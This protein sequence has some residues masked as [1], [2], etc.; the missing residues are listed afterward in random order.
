MNGSSG[1]SCSKLSRQIITKKALVKYFFSLYISVMLE[2]EIEKY[3]VWTVETAGGK[4]YKFKSPTQRGVS[5]RVACMP[6]GETWFIELK[7]K[8]GRLSELKKI[9]RNDVLER[10]Q[11]YAL[12]ASTEEIDQWLKDYRTR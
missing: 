8:V 6:N 4:T 10:Q 3:F 12:L 2:K 9:F 11:R 7:T 5:D 1:L